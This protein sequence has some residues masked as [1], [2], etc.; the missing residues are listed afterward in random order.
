MKAKLVN[1]SLTEHI[2]GSL[3][4]ALQL[5]RQMDP[6]YGDDIGDV[7]F[8]NEDYNS[9]SEEIDEDELD[10]ALYE[11]AMS[12]NVMITDL[13]L[14][15]TNMEAWTDGSWSVMY[16]LLNSAVKG[17]VDDSLYQKAD[18]V[19]M[20]HK[21]LESLV[22]KAYGRDDET[23]AIDDLWLATVY[24]DLKLAYIYQDPESD[25]MTDENVYM[26]FA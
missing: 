11:I 20:S 26:I 16:G 7:G 22:S 6:T 8:E 1:E 23:F 10:D 2:N 12:M 17:E 4:T 13:Y 25:E 15:M 24:P 18:E 5:V 3:P 19:G 21:D 9:L 14:I